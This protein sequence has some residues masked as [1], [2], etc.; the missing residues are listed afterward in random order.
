MM[1]RY[2]KILIAVIFGLSPET[3]NAQ[4]LTFPR[5][6]ERVTEHNLD[7]A[8][9][10]Y[11]VAIA[12]AEIT[13]ARAYPDPE[14]DV[15]FWDNSN[16]R[17]ELGY[18]FSSEMSWT[19]ELGGKRRLRIAVANQETQVARDELENFFIDLRAE[20]TMGYLDALRSQQLLS[21]QQETYERL[22]AL[23]DAD[24][25]RYR[26]GEITKVDAQQSRLEA[27]RMRSDL[28]QAKA[29][30][31]SSL[32]DLA[33]FMGDMSGASIE[34]PQEDLH[35]LER[36]FVL[37][38]LLEQALSKRPS[39]RAAQNK[40]VKAKTQI[41]QAKAA[42]KIDLGLAVGMEHNTEARNYIA[43]TPAF[44]SIHTGVR[45]PIKLSNRHDGELLAARARASQS[46]K[47]LMASE[48]E[49]RKEVTQAFHNY[50]IARKKVQHFQSGVLQQAQIILRAKTYQYQ[51][52]DS[53][54]LDLLDVQR[55]FADLHVDYYDAVYLLGVR[56]VELETAVGMWDIDLRDK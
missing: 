20:A 34:I 31:Q 1:L 45:I 15:Q 56:L 41:D 26:L 42:R 25:V 47:L 27:E 51:R 44:T 38:D 13:G 43:P 22:T 50:Q 12:K 55:T 4:S 7:Y 2:F 11:D 48:L 49:L 28:Y 33:I 6:L 40:L 35:V 18:G 10:H 16:R 32:M 9:A 17:K 24:S 19:L 14:L 36:K 46:E 39:F 8:I 30:L 21:V 5:Y 29:E 3:I 54:L 37:S 23:A 53:S 52:G